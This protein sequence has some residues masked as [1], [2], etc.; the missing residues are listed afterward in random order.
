MKFLQVIRDLPPWLRSGVAALCLLAATVIVSQP[1]GIQGW[2]WDR[3][4]DYRPGLIATV[5]GIFLTLPLFLADLFVM[6]R[7]SDGW[8]SVGLNILNALLIVYLTAAF[9]AI[10]TGGDSWRS[11]PTGLVVIAIIALSIINARRYGELAA[12]TLVV[13]AGW[14]VSE[15]NA[16]MGFWGFWLAALSGIGLMLTLDVE[17]IVRLMMFH[18]GRAAEPPRLDRPEP[19]VPDPVAVLAPPV[20]APLQAPAA[21]ATVAVQ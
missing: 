19:G 13:L 10:G 16:A 11:G 7:R 2:I 20:A 5:I 3:V 15:A 12:L 6:H 1:Y 21:T 14:N 18:G 17:R 8:I 9:A 4:V